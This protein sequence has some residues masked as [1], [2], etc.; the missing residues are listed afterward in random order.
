MLKH[1]RKRMYVKPHRATHLLVSQ[2]ST[3]KSR[4]R[5]ELKREAIGPR[6]QTVRSDHA[7]ASPSDPDQLGEG[8]SCSCFRLVEIRTDMLKKPEILKYKK[9]YK[10]TVFYEAVSTVLGSYVP[11]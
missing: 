3:M 5:S 2:Q 1:Y 9:C 11:K 6:H 8:P 4:F 7:T 10:P